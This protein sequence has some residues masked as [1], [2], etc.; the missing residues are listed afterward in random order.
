VW[1]VAAEGSRALFDRAVLWLIEH[2]VLL[3]GITVLARLVAE[4]RSVEHER[5]YRLLADAPTRERRRRFER[6]LVVADDAR[7]SRL[8]QLRGGRVNISG[9][10]FQ[11]AL[12]RAFDLKGLGAGGLEL[13]D[14]PPAMRR[15]AGKI[16]KAL[17]VLLGI[18]EGGCEE[19]SLAQAWDQI[20]RVIP[21][22]ELT[23]ALQ[24]FLSQSHRSGSELR[25]I[26]GA[27]GV[28]FGVL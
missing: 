8:D 13:P 10:G 28:G 11:G 18:P 2:R 27:P 22:S 7:R 3:P 9:R 19:V 15:A 25:L 21:R 16:A 5:I 14:V 4:V 1:A 6:L 20:E 24:E 26:G 12:E 23:V 17:G